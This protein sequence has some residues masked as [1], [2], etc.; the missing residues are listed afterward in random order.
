MKPE[1]KHKWMAWAII[2]LAIMNLSTIITVVYQKNR[3]EKAE[4]IPESG[5]SVSENA[6]MKYSGRYFRDQLGFTREQMDKFVQ[7]NPDFRQKVRNINIHLSNLRQQMLTGMT[8]TNFDTTRLNFLSDSIG[9]LHADLKKATYNYYLNLK[10]ISN[11]QQQEK[12]EQLF[13]EMFATDLPMGQHGKGG[14][15]WRHRGR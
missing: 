5:I 7:F 8:E 13:S 3:T 1:N 9:Y 4:G 6:S 14:P 10:N 11:T 12:L 2:I 15:G